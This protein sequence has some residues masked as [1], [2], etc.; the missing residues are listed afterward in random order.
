MAKAVV[1]DAKVSLIELSQALGSWKVDDSWHK[2]S[3]IELK[4]W[5]EYVDKKS[6]PTNQ[7]LPS[8]AQAVGACYRNSDPTDIAVTAAGVLVGEVVQVWKPR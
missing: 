5:E 7:T 1:G 6:A 4:S 8:Y 3:R 2:K